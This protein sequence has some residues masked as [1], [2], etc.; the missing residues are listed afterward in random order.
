MKFT[1]QR[2]AVA[3]VLIFLIAL[4]IRLGLT[5][6]FVGL[7]SPPD[8][9]ANSDQVDY[10]VLAY[11]LVAGQGYAV[12][13][14]QPTATRTPGTS[15]TLAPVYAAFGRSFTAGRIWFCLLSSMTCLLVVWLGTAG[16]SRAIGLFAGLGLALYPGHAYNAMHFVSETP[17]GFW[18]MLAMVA[19]AAAWQHRQDSA[20]KRYALDALAGACWA[21]AIYTRP[22]L[23]LAVPFAGGLVLIAFMIRD[24]EPLKHVA[25][26]VVVLS[27]VLSP[28][29]IRNATVLGKPT[30]STIT[31]YGL[32]GAHNDLTFSDPAHHGGWVKSSVLIDDEHPLTGNEVERNDQ[33]MRYGMDAIRAHADQMPGLIAAK[34]WR[35][36]T[37]IK[38]TDNRLV[39]VA[40]AAGWIVVGPLFLLGAVIGIRRST[41]FT[42]LL[43]LPILATLASTVIFY[44]SVRFRDAV[45][46]AFMILAAAG[47]QWAWRRLAGHDSST[48]ISANIPAHPVLDRP[49]DAANR[50]AA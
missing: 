35:L 32:W 25:V 13:P 29:V 41:A 31:G 9:N 6:Q 4:V 8:A 44:G 30:I 23:L 22:Q 1:P 19:T 20:F 47:G 14:G 39:Q 37:P 21:M 28:W 27:L 46:P 48:S 40:F 11:H 2:F 36:M 18:M 15:F 24:R 10:E 5:H 43:T 49:Q 38:D 34:F 42:W 50:H 3:T 17:F 7:A 16:F 45:A 26:Q 33:A 12:T